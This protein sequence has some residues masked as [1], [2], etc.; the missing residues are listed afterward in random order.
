MISPTRSMGIFAAICCAP[1]LYRFASNVANRNDAMLPA[2]LTA[3]SA[4]LGSGFTGCLPWPWA[5]RGHTGGIG[6]V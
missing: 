5:S 3:N 6:P 2:M 1:I 4:C